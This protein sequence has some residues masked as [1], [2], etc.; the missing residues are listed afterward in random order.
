MTGLVLELQRDC[1]N[2][3]KVSEL[4][5]KSL[6]I[7][8]KLNITEIEEWLDKELNGYEYGDEIPS[9]RTIR[10]QL[11]MVDEFSGRHLPVSVDD[12]EL[13]NAFSIRKNG[14]KIAEL[15]YLLDAKQEHMQMPFPA[16]VASSLMQFFKGGVN[17]YSLIDKTQFVSILETVKNKILKWSLDLEQQGILGEGMS[18]SNE[19][20][21]KAQ[22]IHITN[23]IGS[24]H[25]S[26]LQQGSSDLTQSFNLTATQNDLKT[27]IDELKSFISN[28]NL[29]PEQLDEVNEAIATLEIQEKSAKPKLA[30]IRESVE[31]AKGIMDTLGVTP[32]SIVSFLSSIPF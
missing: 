2:G 5:Q 19:E 29:K 18:F 15:E 10:V 20:K 13:A 23:N 16:G 14:Q 6:V 8:K 17:P 24:M 27:V 1:I 25:N 12:E 26:Q 32:E 3:V 31:S 4:L 7:A 9:Y 22:Q 11:M 28:P 30:I 21:Q